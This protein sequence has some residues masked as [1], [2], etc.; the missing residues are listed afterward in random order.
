[1]FCYICWIFPDLDNRLGQMIYFKRVFELSWL[2]FHWSRWKML[3][4]SVPLFQL[5]MVCFGLR[6]G[7]GQQQGDRGWRITPVLLQVACLTFSQR[8]LQGAIS[9]PRKT[10]LR[11]SCCSCL[12]VICLGHSVPPCVQQCLTWQKLWQKMGIVIHLELLCIDAS[13][14]LSS[15]NYQSISFLEIGSVMLCITLPMET[16]Y[17]FL[18]Y[19]PIINI[20]R[21]PKFMK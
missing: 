18:N 20:L 3:V 4:R 9:K 13:E 8:V 17:L 10:K 16:G 6:G 1:M 14:R 5:C 19:F 12:L 2:S 11:P 7:N 15:G 21:Y